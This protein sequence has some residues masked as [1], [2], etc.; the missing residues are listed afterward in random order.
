MAQQ[1]PYVPPADAGGH[2]GTHTAPQQVLAQPNPQDPEDRQ[3][4]GSLWTGVKAKPYGRGGTNTFGAWKA[5]AMLLFFVLL[6]GGLAL[7][8]GYCGGAG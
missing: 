7:L 3:A 2:A 4:V 5:P 6:F 1:Q 8:G